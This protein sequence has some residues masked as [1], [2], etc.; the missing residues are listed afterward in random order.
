MES[1][2]KTQN[3]RGVSFDNLRTLSQINNKELLK[4]DK[5]VKH[6]LGQLESVSRNIRE[7]IKEVSD[8][9]AKSVEVSEIEKGKVVQDRKS[10][11]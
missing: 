11:V 3:G 9:R 1:N 7:Q 6:L 10:V 4:M 8:N 5:D 2:K